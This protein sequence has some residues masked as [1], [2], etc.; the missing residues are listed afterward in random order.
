MR[1]WMNIGKK[2]KKKSNRQL[3]HQQQKKK[4]LRLD[5]L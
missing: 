3:S 4:C 1:K 2:L 5:A